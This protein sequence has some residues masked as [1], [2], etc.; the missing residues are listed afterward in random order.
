M[1]QI[2][3]LTYAIGDRELLSGVNWNIHPGRR[4]ALIGPNGAG[5]T[6]LLRIIHGDIELSEKNITKPKGYQIGYLP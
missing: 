6:T 5:K 4:M 3:N 2:R 1:L